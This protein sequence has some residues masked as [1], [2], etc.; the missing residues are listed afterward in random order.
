MNPIDPLSR[1]TTAAGAT[2]DD[3]AVRAAAEKAAVKFEAY[4]VTQMMRR[5]RDGLRVLADDDSPL[6]NKVNDD[7]LDL[8]DGLVAEQLAGRHAFG[9]ADALLKQLLPAPAPAAPGVTD[10]TPQ[11]PIAR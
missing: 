9:I 2:G 5:M 3:G 11:P 6:K 10:V 8:A 7:M 4:M 1:A